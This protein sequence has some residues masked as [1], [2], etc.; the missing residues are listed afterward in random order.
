MRCWRRKLNSNNRA[1]PSLKTFINRKRW[2]S[3]MRPF[4]MMKV[5]LPSRLSSTVASCLILNKFKLNDN[6]N[7][8]FFSSFGSSIFKTFLPRIFGFYLLPWHAIVEVN[9][10]WHELN[11]P[12]KNIYCVKETEAER[13]ILARS[14]SDFFMGAHKYREMELK[15]HLLYANSSC[16]QTFFSSLTHTYGVRLTF[17][18]FCLLLSLVK[19]FLAQH[20]LQC[21]LLAF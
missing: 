8:F 3:F 2:N 18:F 12:K 15:L 20:C 9:S 11:L 17:I 4:P 10:A 19:L 1:L 21:A 6:N 13:N 16:L 14:F 5:L 7:N